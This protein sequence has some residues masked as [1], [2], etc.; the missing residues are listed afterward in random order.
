MLPN[1]DKAGMGKS[2]PLENRIPM[3]EIPPESRDD[4]TEFRLKAGTI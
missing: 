2:F 4:I 3:A 1:E